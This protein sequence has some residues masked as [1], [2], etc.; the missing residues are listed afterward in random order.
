MLQILL[1]L[2]T[3]IIRDS[4]GRVVRFGLL[5]SK[6]EDQEEKQS[7]EYYKDL[8]LVIRI[9]VIHFLKYRL[10]VLIYI[11]IAQSSNSTFQKTCPIW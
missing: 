10:L 7:R 5:C 1:K 11:Y 9:S 2:E 8:I 4:V 6:I 3:G